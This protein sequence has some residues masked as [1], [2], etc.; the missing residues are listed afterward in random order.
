MQP[1]ITIPLPDPSVFQATARRLATH[2]PRRLQSQFVPLARDPRYTRTLHLHLVNRTW[3]PQMPS[4]R[5]VSTGRGRSR[6]L[7]RLSPIDR[8]LDATL[9]PLAAHW[10]D[11]VLGPS[12]HGW[13]R[14]HGCRSAL[15]SLLRTPLHPD[16]VWMQVDIARL[17]AE[18]PHRRLLETAHQLGGADWAYIL[19]RA[20]A[21]WGTRRGHGLPE[22]ASLSPIL[23][24]VALAQGVDRAL[25]DWLRRGTLL[26]YAR[27][28]DDIVMVLPSDLNEDRLWASLDALFAAEGLR[29]NRRKS[30]VHRGPGPWR[31]LGQLVERGK[32][33]AASPFTVRSGA[34]QRSAGVARRRSSCTAPRPPRRLARP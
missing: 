1:T 12:V 17:F 31:I 18:L 6:T 24:N 33:D 16:A 22:G 29:R 13:R 20:L 19:S 32:E 26:R 15:R 8:V 25:D 3:R 9:A 23:A 34:S 14:G 28:G 27:Y 7:A 4:R 30:V 2:G 21:S 11:G 10:L 5:T